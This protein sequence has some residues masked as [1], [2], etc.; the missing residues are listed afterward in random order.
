[1]QSNH[2]VENWLRSPAYIGPAAA[3][4]A[5]MVATA[6]AA[7]VMAVCRSPGKELSSLPGLRHTKERGC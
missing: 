1:M 4:V 5:A 6:V 2:A 7:A 3:A